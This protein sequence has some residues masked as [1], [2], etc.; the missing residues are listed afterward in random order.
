MKFRDTLEKQVIRESVKNS[1]FGVVI[2]RIELF[3]L[4]I[5]FVV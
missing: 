3:K 4:S 2:F 1:R 5:G